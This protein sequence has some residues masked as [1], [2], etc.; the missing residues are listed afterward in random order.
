MVKMTR[1][2]SPR[3]VGGGRSDRHE[4][5]HKAQGYTRTNAPEW[6]DAGARAAME[7]LQGLSA[8]CGTSIVQE[9]RKVLRGERTEESVVK[10]M[11]VSKHDRAVATSIIGF[12]TRRYSGE[13]S[14]SQ[15]W[16][17]AGW[18]PPG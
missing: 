14:S 4:S 16:S 7:V 1:G 17:P 18:W 3:R 13:G 10:R 11:K 6:S 15:I 8:E 9:A 12:H 2:A 5:R